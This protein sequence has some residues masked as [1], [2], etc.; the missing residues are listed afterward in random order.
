M[1]VDKT[2]DKT[3]EKTRDPLS[4]RKESKTQYRHKG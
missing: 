2:V 1:P 3:D 4:P